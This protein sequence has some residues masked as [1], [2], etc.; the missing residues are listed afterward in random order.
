MVRF[1]LLDVA[2]QGPSGIGSRKTRRIR[3]ARAHMVNSAA[4]YKGAAGLLLED[5]RVMLVQ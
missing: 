3:L 5:A 4:D 2:P 1:L